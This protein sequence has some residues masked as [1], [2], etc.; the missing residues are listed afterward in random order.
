MLKLFTD[1]QPV[2]LKKPVTGC[3]VTGFVVDTASERFSSF[4]PR[5]DVV[6]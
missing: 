1:L 2:L 3:P 4:L 5:P 6:F